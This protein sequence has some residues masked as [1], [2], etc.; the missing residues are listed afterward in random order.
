MKVSPELVHVV[1]EALQMLCDA[2][3]RM[4][5]AWDHGIESFLMPEP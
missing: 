2:K 1:E 4:V 3:P 5:E